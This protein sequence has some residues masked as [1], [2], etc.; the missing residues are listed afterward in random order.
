MLFVVTGGAGFIGS[1]LVKELLKRG[2]K[3]IVID[4]LHTG[5]LENLRGLDVRFI[6]GQARKIADINEKLNG[7]FHLGIYSSSPMYRENKGLI[8][9]AI[10]DW[11]GV[12]EFARKQDIRVVLAS[13][14]SLYNGNPIPWKEDMRIIPTDFYTETRYVMERLARVYNEFYG[15]ECVILRLFSVY[16]SKEEYKGRY[17]NLV[18]QF[19]WSIRKNNP[20]IIFGD[21][22]QTRDFVWVGDVVKAFLLGMEKEISYDVFN[23]GF[24][25]NY[26]LN[27][28]VRV[29]NRTLGKNVEP[30]YVPN[31]IKNYVM[32]TLADTSKA[33]QVLGFKARMKLEDGVKILA[34]NH[35]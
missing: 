19:L 9:E 33:E 15:L 11:I 26:S 10:E 16:G 29:I 7:I 8:K 18:S 5:S 4:N 13:S 25:K 2:E 6:E 32:H 14:S 1:H 34:L 23:V 30:R 3:V 28:L 27:E 35:E 31:P 21:G 24:G 17:A 20:P 22:S 12:M